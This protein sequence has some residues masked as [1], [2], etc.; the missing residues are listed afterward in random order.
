MG[1]ASEVNSYS[2]SCN[3]LDGNILLGNDSIATWQFPFAVAA[4]A[5]NRCYDSHDRYHAA[6]R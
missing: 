1:D 2:T 5:G 4:A 3:L 6:C